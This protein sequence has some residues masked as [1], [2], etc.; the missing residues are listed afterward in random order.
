VHVKNVRK[1]FKLKI[2]MNLMYWHILIALPPAISKVESESLLENDGA[3][4][5]N[6][7]KEINP[8][9]S[10]QKNGWE[11]KEVPNEQYC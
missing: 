8:E 1:V 2:D 6:T 10:L 9:K 3:R 4:S 7:F 11:N 5:K